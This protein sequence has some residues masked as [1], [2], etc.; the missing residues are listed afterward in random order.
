MNYL[1]NKYCP[2][3]DFDSYEDFF[4]NFEINAP[5]NFNFAYDVVDEWACVEP[6]KQALVWVNDADEHKEF[7]F[8]DISRLSNKAANAF[9]DLGISKGDVV[10][11]ILRR[12]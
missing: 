11:M 3:V 1:L 2:R 7:S 9:S 10:M 5:E 8:S 12:R 4:E 6:D